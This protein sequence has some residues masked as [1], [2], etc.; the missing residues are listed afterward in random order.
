MDLIEVLSKYNTQRKC[1]N[2]LESQ[3]WPDGPVCPYCNSTEY[4]AKLNELRYRCTDCGSSF[5]VMV[6]TIFQSTKLPLTKWFAAIALI[7][8]AKKGISSMQLSRHLKVNKNTAWFL[9]SRI[10]QAMS[11]NLSIEGVV[12]IDETFIGGSTSNMH[13]SHIKKKNIY[14]GGKEHKMT[15]LGMIEREQGIILRVIPK[16]NKEY[17]RPILKQLIGTGSTL[18]TDGHGSYVS[19]NKE[20]NKHISINHEKKQRSEGEYNL[21]SIEGFWAL[22][23]RAV[24][25][26]YHSMSYKHLQSYMDEIAFKFNHKFDTNVFNIVINNLLSRSRAII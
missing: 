4:S 25:G 15:V 17:I 19:L 11:E 5:S 13:A 10:R 18:I 14:C 6:G 16:A 9:Q 1:I 23:K 12:E 3:H 21:S 20:F 8:D 22:L 26:V 7:K 2:Y 24:I